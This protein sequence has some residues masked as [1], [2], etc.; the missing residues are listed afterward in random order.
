MT[1]YEGYY[2]NALYE[3]KKNF[4]LFYQ[5]NASIL[6]ITDNVHYALRLPNTKEKL[7]NVI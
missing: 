7:I 4:P 1:K 2:K 6:T 3:T 5:V